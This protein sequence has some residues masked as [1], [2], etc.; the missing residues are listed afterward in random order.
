[1]RAATAGPPNEKR[2]PARGG[3]SNP[4][5]I[6]ARTTY[7]ESRSAR[8][9]PARLSDER[10][11]FATAPTVR[12]FGHLIP[13]DGIVPARDVRVYFNM[14]SP[15]R[16][17]DVAVVFLPRINGRPAPNSHPV[18]SQL[19]YATRNLR[20]SSGHVF[21]AWMRD[22]PSLSI[23]IDPN[24]GCDPHSHPDSLWKMMCHVGFLDDGEAQRARD[25]FAR[26]EE[27]GWARDASIPTPT[28]APLSTSEWAELNGL[29]E[30]RPPKTTPPRKLYAL[31]ASEITFDPD[32]PEEEEELSP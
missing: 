5:L 10:I 1:M 9:D 32:E 27:C 30:P 22:D 8:Q 13:E 24:I 19:R 12:F 17:R 11:G 7:S 16:I 20:C 26:I 14:F 18:R 6:D 15:Q 3:A 29:E 4:N 23:S 31:S 2:H 21:P 25:E 28:A